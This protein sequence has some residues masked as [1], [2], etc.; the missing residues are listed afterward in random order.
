MKTAFKV[1]VPLLLVMV[2]VVVGCATLTSGPA[3]GPEPAT[4]TTGTLTVTP[5]EVEIG[6]AVNISVVVTNTGD[7]EGTYHAVLKVDNVEVVAKDVTLAGG[8]SQTITFITTK[9]VAGTY[10][11]GIG[12]QSG[13]FVVTKPPVQQAAFS[14]SDLTVNPTEVEIGGTVTISVVVT[15]TSDVE[16]TYHAVLKVNNVVVVAKDVTLA[17]GAS[18]TVTFTTTKSTDGTYAV[19]IGSQSGTFMVRSP[20]EP[21]EYQLLQSWGSRGSGDGQFNRPCGVAV[22]AQEQVYVIDTNRVQKLTADGRFLTQWIISSPPNAIAIDASGYVYVAEASSDIVGL[23]EKFTAE[24]ELIKRWEYQGR[25]YKRNDGTVV[26]YSRPGGIAVFGEYVYLGNNSNGSIDKFT[27]DGELVD[28]W[29]NLRRCCGFLDVSV[30]KQGNVYVAELGAFQVKVFDSEGNTVRSWGKQ[31]TGAGDFCPCCN[32]VHVY[33]SP[34]GN[35]VF[36]AE[37]STPRIQVFTTNG[38]HI[39]VFGE[40][41]FSKA[42]SYMDLAVGPS[43]KVYV[44]DD[45]GC[46]I[47]VFG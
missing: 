17:G 39:R 26:K 38:Q 2:L 4:F 42:C 46:C 45:A 20:S 44:V 30:D 18:Q 21:R 24:G 31:G 41:L 15:N 35:M 28:S 34:E 1:F 22:D 29:P 5:T 9:T 40:G 10:A 11:V 19:S 32:P 7:V 23:I 25:E 14:T 6:E 3:P 43:G 13:S 27:T 16:D 33:I 47:R 8:A 12:S 37:K 36:T